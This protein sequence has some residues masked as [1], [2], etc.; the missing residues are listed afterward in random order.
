MQDIHSQ[1]AP[2]CFS[3]CFVFLTERE[4]TRLV[5]TKKSQAGKVLPHKDSVFCFRVLQ[6]TSL[7]LSVDRC[8]SQLCCNSEQTGSDKLYR[9]CSCR[10]RPAR[11]VR[12]ARQAYYFAYC[13]LYMYILLYRSCL[14]SLV[15]VVA[16]AVRIDLGKS[17]VW[18]QTPVQ[19]LAREA[20]SRT[21]EEETSN[22]RSPACPPTGSLHWLF[23][24]FHVCFQVLLP[25][26]LFWF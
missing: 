7:P 10:A 4:L 21:G 9:S 22:G 13:K 16:L 17:W 14:E 6:R 25:S 26:F 20:R 18:A 12:N 5:Q 24:A 23:R 19:S 15:S 8:T 11:V 1:L 3:I 2:S